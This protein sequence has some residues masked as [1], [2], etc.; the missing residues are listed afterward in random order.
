MRRLPLLPLV[1]VLFACGDTDTTGPAHP[2]GISPVNFQASISDASHADGNPHFFF[3]P[4][5]V[6]AASPN[7]AFNPDMSP[8]VTICELSGASECVAEVASFTMSGSPASE[9]IRVSEDDEHYIVNWNTRASAL[10]ASKTYRISVLLGE[11]PLGHADVDVV[12]SARDLRGVDGSQ[13]VGLVRNQTLPIKFRIEVGALAAAVGA[14]CEV[15]CVEATVSS[16]TEETVTTPSLQAGTLIDE[17]ALPE[18]TTITVSISRVEADPCLPTEWDQFEGCYRF[19]HDQG[20]DFEFQGDGVIVG[21]CLELSGQA[22]REQVQL[23]KAEEIEGEAVPPIEALPSTIENFLNCD[24]VS[25]IDDLPLPDFARAGLKKLARVLGPRPAFATDEGFGGTLTKWSRIGWVRP[26]QL[27]IVS[28]D[29]ETV[30]PGTTIPVS[31]LAEAFTS[32]VTHTHTEPADGVPLTLTYVDTDGGFVQTHTTSGGGL[33]SLN[34]TLGTTEGAHTLTVTGPR[35]DALTAPPMVTFTATVEV[36]SGSVSGTVVN[37]QTTAPVQGAT[38][39]LTQGAVVTASTTTASNGTFSFASVPAGAYSLVV[40][41]TGY[42]TTT[43]SLAVD[44]GEAD[45]QT[46][47]LSPVL[48]DGEWRIVLTWG[49]SPTDLDSHLLVPTNS[50]TAHVYWA[51]TGTTASAP[52][53]A[54]DVDD[55]SSFGPETITVLQE[56]TGTYHYYVHN[57]SGQFGDAALVNSGARVDVFKGSSQLASFDVPTTGSG[58]YWDVFTFTGNVVT[59]INVITGVQ[60][61]SAGAPVAGLPQLEVNQRS[62]TDARLRLKEQSRAEQIGNR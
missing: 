4:P 6:G 39:E 17:D 40:S 8:I 46:I 25:L 3:L 16:G 13:F 19:T 54:L 14:T 48:P 52:F 10:D 61:S 24:N 38:V 43:V 2:T 58:L 50:G 42:S 33:A 7:G 22:I 21:V 49:A 59:P 31:V 29:G 5:M 23:Y 45:Q 12:N 20:A 37:S 60:P 62:A 47:A 26:I 57:W 51:N 44:P 36:A 15:D 30:E 18:G 11:T 53:A 35:K 32:T 9:T 28:G 56:Y 41:A 27:A 55:V 34:W 1:V